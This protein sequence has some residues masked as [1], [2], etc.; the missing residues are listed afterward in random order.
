VGSSAGNIDDKFYALLG[1][2]FTSNPKISC[3]NPSLEIEGILF[4]L[5]YHTQIKRKW[6]HFINSQSTLSDILLKEKVTTVD[7]IKL[8]WKEQKLIKLIISLS[9]NTREISL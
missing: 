9:R 2:F 4:E 7:L 8:K 6:M 1:D 3:S 5:A